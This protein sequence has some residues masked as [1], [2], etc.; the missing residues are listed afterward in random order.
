MNNHDNKVAVTTGAS[1]GIGKEAAAIL[2]NQGWTVICIGRNPE[3][4]ALAEEELQII[5][6]GKMVMIC[7]DLALMADTKQA[8]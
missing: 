6:N 8:A 7:A 5:K 2:L 3:R 1:S 4:C